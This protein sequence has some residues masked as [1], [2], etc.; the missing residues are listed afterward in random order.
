[1]KLSSVLHFIALCAL[2]TDALLIPSNAVTLTERDEAA[3]KQ[4]REDSTFSTLWRRKGGGGGGK[5][6]SSSSGSSSGGQ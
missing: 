4:K 2:T 1:M 5:G 3:I 6:G